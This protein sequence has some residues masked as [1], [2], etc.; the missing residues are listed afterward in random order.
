M[1][2]QDGEA[3]VCIYSHDGQMVH[4]AR[5]TGGSYNYDMGGMPRGFYIV[6]VQIFDGQASKIV[7]KE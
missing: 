4:Q 5:A 2:W 1:G 7:A 3:A 6:R